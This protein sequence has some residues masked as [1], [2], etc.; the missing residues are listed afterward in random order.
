[1]QDETLS[2]APD[3][4]AADRLAAFL[5]AE[6]DAR[7]QAWLS[8]LLPRLRGARLG[9]VLLEAEGESDFEAVA[10]E[11][12][13]QDARPL[14]G[15][16]EA[17]L[18][19]QAPS[20]RRLETPGLTG[21]AFPVQGPDGR[22]AAVVAVAVAGE[23]EVAR[24][25]VETLGLACGWLALAF[26]QRERQGDRNV[27]ERMRFALELLAAVEDEATLE[28]GA[29]AFVN[30]LADRLG[31]DRAAVGLLRRGRVRL[32]AVSGVAGLKRRRAVLQAVELAME[33][34]TDQIAPLLWPSPPEH[35][36]CTVAQGEFARQHGFATV[37]TAPLLRLG[38]PVG[39]VS[40]QRRSG[41]PFTAADLATLEV[42]GAVVGPY[43]D[44]ARRNR[45][46]LSGRIP[47]AIG[48][49][50]RLVL[51]PR[52][53][54]LKLLALAS[55]AGLAAVFL[56]DMPLRVAS[57]ATIEATRQ[58]AVVTP[59]DG[60]I[61]EAPRRAGDVVAAGDLIARLDDADFRLEE[62]RLTGEA[63]QLAEQIRQALS[64]GNRA[65][66]AQ[67]VARRAQVEAQLD[68]ARLKL[69]RTELRA[70]ISG[71]IVSGDLSQR[72]GGPTQTG[73][74]LVEVAPLAE[75]RVALAIA[76]RDLRLLAPGQSGQ[77]R[78]S[79][80]PGIALPVTVER[81]AP[82]ARA[83]AG[84]PRFRGEARLEA[85][86]ELRLRPGMEGIAKIETGQASIAYVWSRTLIDWGRHQL[87]RLLP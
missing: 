36:R 16:T 65:E 46:W 71:V 59:F 76:E 21:V 35:R 18:A 32:Q 17:A 60:I 74:V 2:A 57:K 53:P 68:L 45:A 82:M 58:I 27:I 75:L 69:A 73:E 62:A 50:I 79:G 61:A 87:W 30:L 3:R 77:L 40:L 54:G 86:A 43:F 52:R 64:R 14:A 47:D 72:L 23:G 39:A 28:A 9:A 67:L 37:M 1:M 41:A 15:V 51:G 84:G 33:E 78:L 63:R 49:G 5:A 12:P 34:A 19:A 85:P 80:L 29:I 6:G 22:S 25:A 48:S 26:E 10:I 4:L 81:V 83:E 44:L 11:P 24:Q 55:A 38:L 56:V 20:I 66:V 7:W 13:G 42:V 31:A 70:P 8:A